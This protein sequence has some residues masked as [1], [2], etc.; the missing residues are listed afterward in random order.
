[1]KGQKMGVDHNIASLD[2]AV[3]TGLVGGDELVPGKVLELLVRKVMQAISG[4]NCRRV[5]RARL[6]L[7]RPQ[8]H[9][10]E[11]VGL[12]AAFL[13]LTYNRP[14]D[15]WFNWCNNRRLRQ[16]TRWEESNRTGSWGLFRWWGRLGSW[17]CLLTSNFGEGA[18]L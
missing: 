7:G 1:M 13:L 16:G 17:S 14:Q 18:H 9:S 12:V 2:F 3:K 11:R 15:V 10:R 5:S 8:D 4:L 6:A